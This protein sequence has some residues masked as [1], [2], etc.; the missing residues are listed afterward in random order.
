[1]TEISYDDLTKDQIVVLYSS[2]IISRNTAIGRVHKVCIESS[3]TTVIVKIYSEDGWFY[4][5]ND[6]YITNQSNG[7]NIFQVIRNLDQIIVFTLTD[8]EE[9]KILMEFI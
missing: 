6:P 8:D 2:T 9:A 3:N 1:M 5:P 4:T 7:E